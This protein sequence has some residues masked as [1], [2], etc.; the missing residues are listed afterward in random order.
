MRKRKRGYKVY[1]KFSQV[2]PLIVEAYNA[3][4]AIKKALEKARKELSVD[5]ERVELESWTYVEK[6][7][8]K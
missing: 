2:M 1:L 3:S 6:E 4:A 5:G 8:N 7:V